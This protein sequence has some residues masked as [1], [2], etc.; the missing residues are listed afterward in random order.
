MLHFYLFNAKKPFLTSL[1]FAQLGQIQYEN[2]GYMFR[3]SD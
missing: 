1:I 3:H 2:P